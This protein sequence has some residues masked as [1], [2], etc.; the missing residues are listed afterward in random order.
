MHQ[1]LCG[2]GG[3]SLTQQGGKKA[4]DRVGMGLSR[5]PAKDYGTK[6][7][8]LE[9]LGSICKTISTQTTTWDSL[10]SKRTSGIAC[11]WDMVCLRSRIYSAL[12]ISH[13]PVHESQKPIKAEGKK[14]GTWQ[15]P[16]ARSHALM[17]GQ[18]ILF[19]KRAC[20]SGATLGE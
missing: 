17:A 12:P 7:C 8:H 2:D 11:R 4:I 3:Q 6:S 18:S 19:E 1:F 20:L 5:D 13:Q 10:P 14:V 9:R 15:T 16:K